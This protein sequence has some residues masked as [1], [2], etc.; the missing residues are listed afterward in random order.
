M[1]LNKSSFLFALL[2][3]MMFVNAFEYEYILKENRNNDVHHYL[4]S[5]FI[6]EFNKKY[7]L[8]DYQN[9]FV[10]FVQ[11]LYMIAEHNDN[12]NL[13]KFTYRLGI[14]EF[15]DMTHNEFLAKYLNHK[16]LVSTGCKTIAM[17]SSTSYRNAIDWVQRGAV[18]P[19]KD[20]GLSTSR[21][22]LDISLH[23]PIFSIFT[24]KLKKLHIE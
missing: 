20:Q 8:E 1:P 15:A 19:I 9:K 24:E 5:Q 10:P 12:Y 14:N 22:K 4:F 18:N 7:T 21:P 6:S 16:L 13:G 23:I 11:N 2:V 3:G 17:N